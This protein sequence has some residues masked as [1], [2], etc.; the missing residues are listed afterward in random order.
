MTVNKIEKIN[1]LFTQI[2]T[3]GFWSRLFS[4]NTIRDMSIEAMN[5]YKNLINEQERLIALAGKSEV[6]N[7][8]ISERKIEIE[9]LKN[10]LHD[11]EAEA[12]RIDQVNQN[13]Q[14][15][16]QKLNSEISGM[17]GIIE[18]NRKN[19]EEKQNQLGQLE[20]AKKQLN[21]QI[22]ELK[23]NIS[24]KQG[25]AVSLN[26]VIQAKE[27]EI[28]TLTAKNNAGI[29]KINE[30]QKEV[31]A[32]KARHTVLQEETDRYKAEKIRTEE[33]IEQKLE[34][35]T[36]LEKE[37][38]I[39][40]EAN[41]NLQ[42]EIEKHNNDLGRLTVTIEENQKKIIE[43]NNIIASQ[44][45]DL[46]HNQEVLQ[47]KN[48]EIATLNE[49]KNQ[50]EK[51]I[52]EMEIEKAT[53]KQNMENVAQENQKIKREIAT[54][55]ENENKRADEYN[56]KVTTLESFMNQ[57]K[58][59]KLRLEREKEI[60]E[61]EKRER[62]SRAW[63]THEENVQRAI[64]DICQRYSVD[65]IEPQQLPF[66]GNKRPDNTIY[67]AG[68]YII[69]DAKC[70]MK[71]DLD[72][73]EKY[74]QT[75]TEGL[76]KYSKEEK[77]KKDMFLV[78]PSNTLFSDDPNKKCLKK[79]YYNVADYRVFVVAVD[80]L[81]PVILNLKKIEEYEFANQLSPEDRDNIC[82]LIANLLH[83]SKRKIQFDGILNQKFLEILKKVDLLPEEINK[84][85][86]EF[87]K[88]DK[89]KIPTDKNKAISI[90]DTMQEID[91]SKTIMDRE[92]INR[93]PELSQELSMLPLYK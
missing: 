65:Y 4:W 93:S 35:I 11:K 12:I 52:K 54:W 57:L 10:R 5:E 44:T 29:E 24:E 7:K 21:L 46:K 81:E 16:L 27:S 33:A 72:S 3:M 26:K 83:L 37:I 17:N 67:I 58:E 38:G 92:N 28:G 68:E 75:Q 73:F 53:I 47:E 76:S 66:K 1:S 23:L 60:E 62:M 48:R 89:I 9:S 22:Q 49:A 40:Q 56:T 8:E 42:K 69:F 25:E 50:F 87:E 41:K 88:A 74:I 55:E 30:M 2:K 82:N 43:L 20:E 45:Q 31:E 59:D 91:Y 71:E 15:R 79:F 90:K 70:P 18:I 84:K 80:S 63:K 51:R 19:L 39:K 6:L 32:F 61:Q 64:T 13:L 36:I 77:V 14:E 85:V 34:N 86:V 78:V